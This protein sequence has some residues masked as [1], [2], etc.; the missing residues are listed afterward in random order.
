MMSPSAPSRNRSQKNP[1]RHAAREGAS[2]IVA[3]TTS[4]A[5]PGPS[6]NSPPAGG[7]TPRKITTQ[8]TRQSPIPAREPL[9]ARPSSQVPAARR[10]TPRALPPMTAR[11]ASAEDT[12]SCGGWVSA[13]VMNPESHPCNPAAGVRPHSSAAALDGEARTLYSGLRS[14]PVPARDSPEPAILGAN[15]VRD[16]VPKSLSESAG[17]DPGADCGVVSDEVRAV[18]SRRKKTTIGGRSF[19]TWTFRK[20]PLR[21]HELYAPPDDD[22][23]CDN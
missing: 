20:P 6:R 12:H 4:V 2:N 17:Y 19:F 3:A 10:L 21:R 16:I 5:S 8:A 14:G 7:S 15:P 1:R 9:S 13:T 18:L 11:A 23:D 22:E